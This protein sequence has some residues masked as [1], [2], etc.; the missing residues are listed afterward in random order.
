MP[1]IQSGVNTNEHAIATSSGAHHYRFVGIEI[2]PFPGTYI[3]NLVQ[4]GNQETDASQLPHNITFDRCYVHGDAVVDSR[5]GIAMDGNSIAVID[6][7]VSNFREAGA[8]N[9]ALWAHNGQGPYKIVNNYLSGAGENLMFGGADPAIPNAV[10][11]DIEIRFN[12]FFKPLTWIGQGYQV[13]NLLEFKNASRVLVEGNTFENNWA[14]AQDGHSILLTPR[15]QNGGCNWCRVQD[16]TIRFNRMINLAQGINISGSD[17]AFP[18]LRTERILLRNN[19][20][21]ITSIKDPAFFTD[22]VNGRPIQILSGPLDVTIDHNTAFT[23]GSSMVFSGGFPKTDGLV[24]TNNLMDSGQYGFLGTGTGGGNGTLNAYYTGNYVFTNNAI[25]SSNDVFNS[26][27]QY[28]SGNF[29]S[30]GAGGVGFV[31]LAG[32]DYS[33]LGTSPYKNAGT[34]GKDIGADIG[35]LADVL[36]SNISGAALPPPVGLIVR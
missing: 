28:P 30:L 14:S 8:D 35:T 26:Q 6:S 1:V 20:M 2:R 5:R 34:D 9:Q 27:A 19:V 13:K 7:H 36:G 12:H 32:G 23:S 18:S 4:I 3:T 21:E 31:D 10:P 29:F 25:I 11:S 15:N 33:L 17:N 16:I 24:F 22:D